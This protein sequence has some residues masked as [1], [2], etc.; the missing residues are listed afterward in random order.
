MRRVAAMMSLV[1]ATTA[2]AQSFQGVVT[3]Q[4]G[5]QNE[6]MIYTGSGGSKVRIDMN[7]PHMPAGGASIIWDTGANSMMMV[8]NAQKMYMTMDMGK[9]MANT[10]A[11]TAR[12]K[13]T[14]VGSEVVAG[15]PCDDYK[16]TS[17]S[18]TP[19]TTVC[20][21]H[22]MGN[23]LWFG[24]NNPMMARMNSRVSG[25]SSAVAGG[26]FP[27]KIMKADGTVDMI[28]TKVD[29]HSVDPSLF[30]PPAGFT[31]MQMPA[32]MQQH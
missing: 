8:M 31:Q 27:L 23:F 15:V 5:K 24:G 4:M 32:G 19:E 30:A 20:I 11:D 2:G 16:G 12:G 26:G 9:M 14:K 25:L 10:G 7:D 6:T 3:Y 18:G 28:A 17:N 29:K 21:A 13:L 1:V 22:G